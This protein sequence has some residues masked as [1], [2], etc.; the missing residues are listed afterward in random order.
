MN[1]NSMASSSLS[2]KP[3]LG[4]ALRTEGLSG[5]C[6]DLQ[7]SSPSVQFLVRPRTVKKLRQCL[8]LSMYS[9]PFTSIKSMT[10]S[11]FHVAHVY[12]CLLAWNCLAKILKKAL[13]DAVC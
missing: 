9:F 2:S 7:K 11:V 1:S 8:Y 5:L 10:L 13:Y 12:L 3:F 4:S 6:S